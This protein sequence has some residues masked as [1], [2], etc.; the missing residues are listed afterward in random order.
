MSKLLFCLALVLGFTAFQTVH[1]QE[2]KFAGGLRLSTAAPTIASAVSL[3]YF[4]T[5]RAAVEGLVAFGNRFGLGGLY[6]IHGLIGASP[7][8]YWF[9]GGGAYVGFEAGKVYTGPM[10]VVGIDY[11]FAD[12]PINLSLDW[13]PELDISP[14]I[15]FVPD[16]LALS[17]RF[18]LK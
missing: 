11:K 13:K 7:G 15:N 12:A 9:Y 18:T 5:D 10:G 8:L 1:A 4:L 16:A 3:K 6:E 17:I 14:E 2:Y